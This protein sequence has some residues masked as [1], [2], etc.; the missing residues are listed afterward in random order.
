VLFL[1]KDGTIKLCCEGCL[2]VSPS[3][4]GPSKRAGVMLG[5]PDGLSQSDRCKIPFMQSPVGVDDS[6]AGLS[7]SRAMTHPSLNDLIDHGLCK[8]K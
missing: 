3:S 1:E 6:R 4:T 7:G 2:D 8:P 5:R